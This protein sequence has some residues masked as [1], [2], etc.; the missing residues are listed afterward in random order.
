MPLFPQQCSRNWP[1][2]A[3]GSPTTSPPES[4]GR[5]H[6]YCEGPY[7]EGAPA[8]NRP[9]RWRMEKA[10]PMQTGDFGS[11]ATSRGLSLAT[12]CPPQ[13]ARSLYNPQ[14][15]AASTASAAT[16]TPATAHRVLPVSDES[17][18]AGAP[19]SDAASRRMCVRSSGSALGMIPSPCAPQLRSATRR[20]LHTNVSRFLAT[21][22]GPGEVVAGHEVIDILF[23]CCHEGAA[24]GLTKDDH[25]KHPLYVPYS[26]ELVAFAGRP[27]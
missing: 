15:D 17:S 18:L 3:G 16:Q 5:R 13:R 14:L 26:A 25:P 6:R 19:P 23:G 21:R 24:P 9:Q 8:A 27:A 4:V 1:K 22:E 12:P 20:F 10:A 11:P 7:S 2:T